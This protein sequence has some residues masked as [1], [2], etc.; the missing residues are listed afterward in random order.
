MVQDISQTFPGMGTIGQLNIVA[1]Y[2]QLDT[3]SVT[4][5]H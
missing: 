3:K 2:M 4:M 1:L 5:F